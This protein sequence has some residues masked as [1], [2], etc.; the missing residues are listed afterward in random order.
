MSYMQYCKE[1]KVNERAITDSPNLKMLSTTKARTL[2]K[3]K[4]E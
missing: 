2:L 3:E 1:L 4:N